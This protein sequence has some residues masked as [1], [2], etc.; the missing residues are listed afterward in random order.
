M[1]RGRKIRV[2]TLPSSSPAGTRQHSQDDPPHSDAES[3][4]GL[5]RCGSE[6]HRASVLRRRR[7]VRFRGALG[8]RQKRL[9]RAL[10][11]QTAGR[12]CRASSQ[13]PDRAVAPDR[14]RGQGQLARTWPVTFE[15]PRYRPCTQEQCGHPLVLDQHAIEQYRRAPRGRKCSQRG[16]R[17]PKEQATYYKA[18]LCFRPTGFVLSRLLE[19]W[20]SHLEW[21]LI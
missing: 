19:R 4:E 2:W 3:G 17:K 5:K 18:R 11:G 1:A 8:L 9:S 12:I 10:S 15:V 14:R 7:W 21:V 16:V 13:K 6:R 20:R